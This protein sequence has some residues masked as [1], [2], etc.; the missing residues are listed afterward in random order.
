MVVS[1]A[2]SGIEITVPVCAFENIGVNHEDVHLMEKGDGCD[3][4]AEDGK[5]SFSIPG[6]V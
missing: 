3:A 1:C 6:Q 5:V 2:P 4:S